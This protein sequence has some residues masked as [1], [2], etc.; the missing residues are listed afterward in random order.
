MRKSASAPGKIDRRNNP[1][2]VLSGRRNRAKPAIRLPD[3]DS[4]PGIHE[5]Q[6]AGKIQG[7]AG[8][9]DKSGNPRVEVAL[10]AFVAAEFRIRIE[11]SIA[12]AEPRQNQHGETAAGEIPRH[13]RVAAA[14]GLRAL[15]AGVFAPVVEDDDGERSASI[16]PVMRDGD[17][18]GML[19]AVRQRHGDRHARKCLVDVI[20]EALRRCRCRAEHDR[21]NHTAC[22]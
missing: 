21:C 15:V 18:A 20:G 1:G 19:L 2:K 13:V 9:L 5:G 14:R 16:G 7:G 12:I 3:Q 22:A 4:A 8:L 10:A 6:R 11:S 17:L